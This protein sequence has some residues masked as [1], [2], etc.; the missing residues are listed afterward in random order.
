MTIIGQKVDLCTKIVKGRA[1]AAE[2][3]G[4][5]SSLV[6]SS[7]T[8]SCGEMKLTRGDNGKEITVKI[9]DVLQIELER[10]GGTG[11]EWYLDQSYKK[12]F[13]VVGEDTETRQSRG[14][15]G[16]PVVRKWKLRAIERGETDVRLLLYREW[17]G[18]DKA[19]E[20]F[21]VRVKIL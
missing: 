18:K 8:K 1:L 21:K 15:V 11:Y 5:P 9:G 7:S 12:Y 6:V 2:S 14:L 13:E 16:T 20:T 17:E 19:V 3:Y 4:N 10:S